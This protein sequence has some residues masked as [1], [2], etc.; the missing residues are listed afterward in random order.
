MMLSVS[1]YYLYSPL[2]HPWNQRH[3]LR[4]RWPGTTDCPGDG[5]IKKVKKY[6]RLGKSIVYWAD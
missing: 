3:L 6:V 5:L 2:S 4:D 1:I